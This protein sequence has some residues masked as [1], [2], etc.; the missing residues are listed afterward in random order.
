MQ[1][2]EIWSVILFLSRQQF[3]AKQVFV[4]SSSMKVGLVIVRREF[5]PSLLKWH[6][7]VTHVYLTILLTI[8]ASHHL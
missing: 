5:H 3:H 8:I 1:Q 7:I 6:F 4:L 2:M